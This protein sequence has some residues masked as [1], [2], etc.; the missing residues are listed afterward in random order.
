MERSVQPARASLRLSGTAQAIR[1]AAWVV[2]TALNGR[3]RARARK[4]SPEATAETLG[5]EEPPVGLRLDR[6]VLSL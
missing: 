4:M 3:E 6:R 2:P 1:L 5:V